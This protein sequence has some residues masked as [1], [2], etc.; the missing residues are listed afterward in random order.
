MFYW[1]GGKVGKNLFIPKL[2]NLTNQ[3]GTVNSGISS[4]VNIYEPDGTYTT[5][6]T[7]TANNTVELNE[8]IPATPGRL[9]S[10]SVGS[11][12]SGVFDMSTVVP[13]NDILKPLKFVP[14]HIF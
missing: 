5:H 10:L 7:T 9:A 8:N 3:D 1:V 6:P 4:N 11:I 13:V 2:K 12:Q 14:T